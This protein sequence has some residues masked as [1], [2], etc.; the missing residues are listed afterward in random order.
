MDVIFG[1]GRAGRS[2]PGCCVG[3]VAAPGAAAGCNGRSRL[4]AL[5]AVGS[6]LMALI[7]ET[8]P[9]TNTS[10]L[11]NSSAGGAAG[12]GIPVLCGRPEAQAAA[13]AAGGAGRLRGALPSRGEVAVQQGGAAARACFRDRQAATPFDLDLDLL[14]GGPSPPYMRL[15]RRLCCRLTSLLPLPLVS[16]CLV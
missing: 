1:T 2:S 15:C 10:L 12:G 7:I 3:G 5:R 14:R 16:C 6:L 4:A 13:A 11:P 9:P 8:S